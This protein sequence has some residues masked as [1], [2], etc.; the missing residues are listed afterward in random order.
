MIEFMISIVGC[1]IS[2]K[3][4]LHIIEIVGQSC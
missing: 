4:I 2:L 3:Y 1:D